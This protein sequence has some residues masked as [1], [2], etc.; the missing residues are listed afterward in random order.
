MGR[1]SAL[2]RVLAAWALFSSGQWMVMVALGVYAYDRS[3]AGG[4]AAVTVA[5]LL[6]SVLVAPVVGALVD[7]VDRARVVAGACV[8]Q[9]LA[10]AALAACVWQE[11]AMVVVAVVTAL[12][13]AAGTPVRPALQAIL[14]ALARTP[15]ELTRATAGWGAVDSVGFLAGAG[16][17]GLLVAVVGSGAVLA[18]SAA[19]ALVT[20]LVIVGLPSTRATVAGDDGD[21]SSG[22]LAG[23]R[24]VARTRLLHAPFALFVGLLLL[25]GATDVLL[26]A[27]AIDELGLGSGGPG[28]LYAAW[29]AGGLLGSAVLL[30]V[31]RRAGYGRALLLGAAVFGTV[32]GLSGVGGAAVVVVA[33]VP[34]GLGFGLVESA[35]MGVVPRLADDAVIGRVYAVCEVLYAGVAAL[36]AVLTPLLIHLVGVRGGLAVTGAAYAL[37]ALGSA[38]PCLR[39]DRGE[40]RA[41][42][43]RELLHGVPFLALLPLPQL[44]R[45]VRTARPVD[46][47]AGAEVFHLGDVGDEFFVVETGAIDVTEFG[48]RLGPGDGFG[49]VALLQDVP[50]TSTVLARQ[51]ATLWAVGRA[52]FL[53]AV[54]QRD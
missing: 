15:A 35:M 36:G 50:R 18:V 13:A 48:R 40:Q 16:L 8:L 2:V 29:G 45:L 19:S 39:L 20:T 33:M 5:R 7:R 3:G 53:A 47:P 11:G 1:S 6:P 9:T 28:L 37:L 23:L 24:V 34:V 54:Q 30:A 46:V 31:V 17:G 12:A 42:R 14:P 32:L 43:V 22:V 27:L 52:P 10:V 51:D 4:V 26:V 49:E 41:H 44:E 25:E 38:Y 21:D